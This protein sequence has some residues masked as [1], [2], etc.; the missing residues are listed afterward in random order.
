MD[1]LLKF[2]SISKEEKIKIFDKMIKQAKRSY[3]NDDLYN[4]CKTTGFIFYEFMSS[5]LAK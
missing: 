1:D 5:K 3:N 4:H 2:E